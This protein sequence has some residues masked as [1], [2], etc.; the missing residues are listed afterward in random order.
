MVSTAAG[1]RKE[2]LC[3]SNNLHFPK[4]KRFANALVK[5]KQLFP[6]YMVTTVHKMHTSC[7]LTV[8]LSI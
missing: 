2:K 8:L 1:M 3:S 4:F 6:L 7:C 5:Q